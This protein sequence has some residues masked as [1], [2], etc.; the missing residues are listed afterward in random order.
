VTA[1]R[2]LL[3]IALV[4]TTLLA[5]AAHAAPAAEPMVDFVVVKTDTLM[6]LSQ[7]VLVSPAA[8]R[9]VAK[10]NRLVNPN[11]ILPGQRLK[12]PTRLLR[13]KPVDAQLVSATGDVRIGDAPAASGT[14]VTEGQSVQ[15]G[16]SS[17][18]V[19]ELA[20]GSR[21]RLPPS[22]LAQVVASRRLGER[23]EAAAAASASD[24]AAANAPS[25]WFAGSMRVL[26]GSVE[27]FASK[28]L[29]AKPLEVVTPTAVVGVRGTSY[30]VGLDDT[31]N[32]RTRGEVIEG[33]V[34]F[35]TARGAGA[36]VASGFGAAADASGAPP[37]VVKLQAAPDLSAVPARFER[38]LVRF[39]LPSETTAMRVQIA[40]DSAFDKIV[41]DQ[42]VAAGAE[43]RVAGL[44]DASWFLRA[45]RIDTQGI[46]GFDATR[47]FV[48]KA[49][50]EPPVYRAPRAN[51]KQPAGSI[52]FAWAL[53]VE[54]PQVRVQIAE[55]EAFT[56]LVQDRDLLAG[57]DL[58]ADITTPGTY[59]WRA[60]SVR[61]DGDHGPFGDAQT[62]V[63]R[64]LPEP[65]SAG[66]SGDGRALV[67]TWGGRAEDKQRVELARDLAFT[68]IVASAELDQPQ[69]SLATPSRS[70]RYYFRYRSVEPDGYISPY[71]ATAMI[72][73]PRNWLEML[74]AFLPMLLIF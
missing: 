63:V 35:D 56:K 55:D 21:V 3:P 22:S 29:R 17:S 15:T 1:A 71:S 18:A 48:L 33:L 74:P 9:E 30:R 45:R 46:E 53:N 2:R 10:L 5:A 61:P 19:I 12:I 64:P 57:S 62:F 38:P 67:F 52:E 24:A 36:D 47:P 44:D 68:D 58:R 34:R 13:E 26:R 7:S 23:G 69:W 39:A 14:A 54:A 50:P 20:D 27:V 43:V 32:G 41:S 31:A 8:W 11:L 49:R 66:L 28:V 25:G 40:S 51:G 70:G 73:V 42:R 65:P 16:A 72:D 6:G 4:A 59:F 37:S 60:A